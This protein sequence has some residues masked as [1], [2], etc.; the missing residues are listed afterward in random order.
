MS[1]AITYLALCPHQ[2]LVTW[3]M[4]KEGDKNGDLPL[5]PKWHDRPAD[6]W[7]RL[8]TLLKGAW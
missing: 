4:R 2:R 5:C 1:V 3:Q 6:S 7:A 8:R